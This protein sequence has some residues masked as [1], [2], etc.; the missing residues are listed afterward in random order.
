[1][2]KYF[3]D[4]CEKETY[5]LQYHDFTQWVQLSG[6]MEMHEHEKEFFARFYVCDLC[7]DIW[8]RLAEKFVQEVKEECKK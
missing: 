1:M 4:L 5:P 3:C 7:R 8:N 2:K 6:V